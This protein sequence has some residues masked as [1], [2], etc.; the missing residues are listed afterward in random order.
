M[1]LASQ[2]LQNLIAEFQSLPGIGQKTAERL[3][4]FVLRS[5]ADEAL[6]LADAIRGVKER[7]RN[8]KICFNI[9]EEEICAI[10]EDPA[11][12]GQTLCVVEQPKD[13]YAVEQTGSFRGIYHVLQGAFAPL[14]GVSPEDLTIEPLV[15]RIKEGG[16]TEVILA[17][18]P[19][20]EGEGTA[21]YIREQLKASSPEVQVTRIARGMPSGSNLEHVSRNIVTDALEGRQKM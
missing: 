11:R 19:N 18:N 3:A 5:P 21:L 20:F 4:Y 17:T 12:D 2:P 10:C 7:I 16:V 14:E 8:C 15:Q 1:T 13:V 6:K 9:A